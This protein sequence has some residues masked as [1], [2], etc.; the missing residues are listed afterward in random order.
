LHLP[1][2]EIFQQTL[3]LEAKR[4][5]NYILKHKAIKGFGEKKRELF[6]DMS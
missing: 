3:G 5:D 2:L 6:M 1:A 4:G